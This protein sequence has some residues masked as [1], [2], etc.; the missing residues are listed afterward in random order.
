MRLDFLAQTCGE[1][2]ITVSVIGPGNREQCLEWHG[3]RS[4]FEKA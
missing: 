1:P 4:L 3:G 2:Q